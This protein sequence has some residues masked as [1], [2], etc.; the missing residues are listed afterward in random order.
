MC[1]PELSDFETSIWQAFEQ[2]SVVVV[3]I[4]AVNQNQINEFVSANGITY[5]ILNDQQSNSGNGP[6]GFGG[7]TY[8]EY[9]IPTQGSPYPRD[10]I[11]SQ[12]GTIVYANNEIDTE[13]II[14]TIEDLLEQ[15]E[16]LYVYENSS[17]TPNRIKLL[18]VFPNPFNPVANIQFFVRP[19]ATKNYTIS[20]YN[21]TGQLVEKINNKEF[22]LGYN[23]IQWNAG[24]H[25][26]GIYFT[27]LESDNNFLTQKI[28]LLK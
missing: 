22:V 27:R 16:S 2:D 14:Y 10:F 28:I 18:T 7:V 6:G 19:F 5:P 21:N 23:T 26:S 4:T 1:S 20:I 15:E 13:Q 3:G 17:N 11:V 24:S 8:D 25:P 9:Y 12:D